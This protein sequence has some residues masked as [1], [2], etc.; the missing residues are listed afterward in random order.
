MKKI[1]TLLFLLPFFMTAKSQWPASTSIVISQL[2]GGGGSTNV[3]AAY[4]RDY[5][6]LHNISSA[7]VTIPDSTWSL[8]YGG[9]TSNIGGSSSTRYIIASG[10]NPKTSITIPAGGYLLIATG[11]AS[12]GGAAISPTPDLVTS[13]LNM[14]N[15]NGKVALISDTTLFKCGQAGM[16]G[17]FISCNP[18]QTAKIIDLVGFGRLADS[19]NTNFETQTT[20]GIPGDT[21]TVLGGKSNLNIRVINVR[22]FSG[23]QESQ[24]NAIDFDTIPYAVPRNSASP[25]HICTLAEITAPVKL[26]SFNIAKTGNNV[27][28]SWATQQEINNKAFVIQRSND[29]IN[30]WQDL[31]TVDAVGNSSIIVNYSGTDNVPLNGFNYYRLKQINMDGSF[32]FSSIKKV[33]FSASYKVLVTPNPAKDFI[34]VYV[35]KNNNSTTLVKVINLNGQVVRSESSSLSTISISTNGIAKGVYFV[36]IID[37][38]NVTTKKISVQ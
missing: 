20:I 37:A 9:A 14:S 1:F 23:C 30:N 34:N 33:L 3:T 22:K 2:Y 25:V 32:T 12:T 29:G 4:V 7:A 21:T 28:L 26:S 31:T 24:N 11:T 17:G 16:A 38:N 35:S 15:S 6:E 36:K 13:S 19:V 10:T 18:T 5:I 8:Q 27:N